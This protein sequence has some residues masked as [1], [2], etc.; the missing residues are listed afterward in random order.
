MK[1]AQNRQKTYVDQR[2]RDLECMIGDLAFVKVSSMKGAVRFRIAEKPTPRF[3]R[4]FRI[5][6]RIGSLVY[7]VE[8]PK[9][10]S[11]FYNVYLVS[12]LRMH[13]HDPS[14]IV[15]TSV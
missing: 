3:I 7:I 14:L 8:F 6:E 10:L 2:G 11:E 9:R 13:V 15:E 4:P 12:H 5:L 1:E